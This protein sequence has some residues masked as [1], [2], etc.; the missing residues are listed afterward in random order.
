M[1]DLPSA[2]WDDEISFA[3]MEYGVQ[4][5]Q[6]DV[7]VQDVSSPGIFTAPQRDA[8]WKWALGAGIVTVGAYAIYQHVT[9][10]K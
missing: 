5:G 3:V 2:G 1:G 10:G 6:H 7:G 4:T 9:G 8:W